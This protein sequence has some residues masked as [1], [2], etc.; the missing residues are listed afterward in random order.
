MGG[1]LLLLR[2]GHTPLVFFFSRKVWKNTVDG[3]NARQLH[4]QIPA[5]L[6]DNSGGDVQED[7]SVLAHFQVLMCKTEDASVFLLE[8]FNKRLFSYFEWFS[9]YSFFIIIIL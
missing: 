9:L 6:S 4:M 1:V 2:E 5:H 8:R 3:R 7:L